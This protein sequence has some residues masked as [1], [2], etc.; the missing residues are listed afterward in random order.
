MKVLVGTS[1]LNKVETIK[2][3]VKDTDIEL[4]TPKDLKIKLEVEESGSTP[5]ENAKLKALAYYDKVKI[6]V[7]SFDSG[8]YFINVD[9]NDKRQPGVYV[10]RVNGKELTDDEMIQHYKKVAESF[11][12]KVK[13]SYL[14]G[15]C[16]VMD[17]DNIYEFMD[18][19]LKTIDAYSFYLVDKPHKKRTPGWPLD[20]LS[21]EESTGKYFVEINERHIDERKKKKAEV[22]DERLKNFYCKALGI[23]N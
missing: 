1:N 17:K 23:D 21:V 13:A 12:G 16:I 18:T 9:K 6:P 11:G 19:D 3:F 8:L 5:V 10:R 2:E 22:R 20:S 4:I 14:N 15:Y 7:I